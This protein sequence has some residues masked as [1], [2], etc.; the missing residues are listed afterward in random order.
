[1]E[2]ST[3]PLESLTFWSG[4][5][6]PGEPLKVRVEDGA[7][8]HVNG[9]CVLDESS[10]RPAAILKVK[11]K[12]GRI[13]APATLCVLQGSQCNVTLTAYFE[14]TATFSAMG[15][16]TIHLY[17]H[18]INVMSD[19]PPTAEGGDDGVETESAIQAKMASY[20]AQSQARPQ[21]Q[22][23]GAKR[24]AKTSS[25]EDSSGSSDESSSSDD[26]GGRNPS[27]AKKRRV[28]VGPQQ[29]GN[30][31]VAPAPN[32]NPTVDKIIS[33]V[34]HESPT[35]SIAL[36]TLGS[37]FT[38][39]SGGKKFKDLVPGKR[40]GAY[41]KEQGNYTITPDHHVKFNTQH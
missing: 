36:S 12:G 4:S 29:N 7:L 40:M 11:C 18:F 37:E 25:S 22:S 26:E 32:A 13:K 35:K 30:A 15:S 20:R 6:R 24:A 39:R 27:L 19:V 5:V 3:L 23:V 34:I 33:D 14:R 28:E 10:G 2:E 16:G 21:P 1:M 41:I 31:G 8:L 17:G 9:A 38:K